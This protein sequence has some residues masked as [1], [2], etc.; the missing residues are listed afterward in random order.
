[1]ITARGLSRRHAL[2]RS[3]PGGVEIV[4]LRSKNGIS[5]AGK[6]VERVR[7]TPGLGVHLGT[8]WLELHEI[9]TTEEALALMARRGAPAAAPAATEE[10]RLPVAHV[11]LGSSPEAALRLAYSIHRLGVGK[12]G[13]RTA[14]LAQ[15]RAVLGAHV[16][17]VAQRLGRTG[18][19][20]E[21]SC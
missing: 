17:V 6:R 19:A 13:E 5:I 3:V 12:P 14:L 1:V 2:V 4:D 18:L 16:V 8:V 11:G 10:R 9:S 7:L 15:A 21:E 20:V